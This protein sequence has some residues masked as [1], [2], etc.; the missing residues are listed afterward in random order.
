MTFLSHAEIH[1]TIT[2][3]NIQNSSITTKSS[4]MLLF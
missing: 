3:F 2:T 4:L 1:R